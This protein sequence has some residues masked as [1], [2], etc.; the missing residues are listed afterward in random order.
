MNTIT[1]HVL[2]TARGHPAGGVPV[3]LE[4][5]SGEHNWETLGRAVTDENGRV[6]NLLPPGFPL[7]EGN[8]R[9]TFDTLAYYRSQNA[10]GFHPQV[11]VTF[12]VRK[13]S[14]E[15]SQHYHIPLLLSPYGYTTYRGS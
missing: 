2:D 14:K 5:Q 3:L 13:D 15:T 6:K 7:P 10:E 1:T 8:Y 9:L 11:T 4:M 12:T